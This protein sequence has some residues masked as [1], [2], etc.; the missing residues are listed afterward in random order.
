MRIPIFLSY[1]KPHLQRQHGFIERIHIWL[2]DH[3]FEPRTLGVSDYDNQEPLAAIRR[4]MLESN[5]ILTVAFRRTLIIQ[6]TSNPGADLAGSDRLEQPIENVWTTSLYC[7]IEPAMAF[8][9]GLPILIVRESGVLED[10]LLDRGVIGSYTPVFNLDD[11]TSDFFEG[12]EWRQVAGRWAGQVHSVVVTK[13][14][15]PRLY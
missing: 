6:G 1:P 3:D 5:G 8:Q 11:S 13:G 10:G 14:S 7:H 9:L 15:P 2:L 4:L 12:D